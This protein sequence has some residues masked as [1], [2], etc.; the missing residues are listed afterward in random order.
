MSCLKSTFSKTIDKNVNTCMILIFELA[1]LHFLPSSILTEMA[2][3]VYLFRQSW[4]V[5]ICHCLAPP[6]TTHT[7]I[8]LPHRKLTGKLERAR[9]M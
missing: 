7:V 1:F 4:D 8:K 6:Y 2:K 5:K 3:Y 9:T